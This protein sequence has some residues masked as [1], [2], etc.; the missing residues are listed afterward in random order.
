LARFGSLDTQYFDDAGN[1]LV[2]G[3]IY[4]YETGTTT[5]KNTYADPSYAIPNANPVILT[6]AGRQPNIF[7]PGAAKAILAKSDDTQILVRDPVGETESSFGDAWIASKDYNANAVVQGSDGQFYVSLINGNVN[8][9]PVTTSGSWTFLYSVEWNAG[10]TYKLGSVVTYQS[11]VYQSLQNANL[12]Q[13]PST[14]TAFWVPIQLVWSSTSTYALHA[15]VVGT[16]GVLYTSIQAANTGNVPA[17][18]PLWWAGTSA[19]AAASAAAASVSQSAALASQNAAAASQA[20]ATASQLAASNSAAA[21]AASAAA[22][23]AASNAA[24]WVSG[25]AYLAGDVVWSPISFLSYRA[26]VNTSGTT[27]PSLSANWELLNAGGITNVVTATTATTLTNTKTLLQITPASYGVVVTLPD[28][29]TMSEGGP[30]HCIDNRGNYHVRVWDNDGTLLGFVSPGASCPVY[31]VDNSTAAGVWGIVGRE[32]IGISATLATANFNGGLSLGTEGGAGAV[33]MGGGFEVLLG[34]RQ[35]DGYATAVVHK[36][37]T[38]EFGAVSVFRAANVGTANVAGARYT[39]TSLLVASYITTAVELVV[40]SFNTGTLA[41]TVNTPLAITLSASSIGVNQGSML[42]KNPDVADS[43]AFCVL[44]SGGSPQLYAVNVSGTTVTASAATT[45]VGTSYSMQY[46]VGSVLVMA[47]TTTTSLFV[48]PYT[49][50]GTTVTAGTGL[51]ISGGTMTMNRFF[52][53]GSRLCILY[54]DGGSTI[55]GSIVSL[56]G[57]TVTQS[58]ATLHS[59]GTLADAAIV[60]GKVLTLNNQSTDNHNLLTDSAGTASAGTP[61]S[62]YAAGL[63]VFSVFGSSALTYGTGPYFYKVDCSGASPTTTMVY[64]TGGMTTVNFP[65]GASNIGLVL[66]SKI[67]KAGSNALA[68]QDNFGV[69]LT[70][71]TSGEYLSIVTQVFGAVAYGSQL[72][73]GRNDAERWSIGSSTVQDY[74]FKTELAA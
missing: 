10:T 19:A 61:A 9:N 72:S 63:Y 6:A 73:R 25:Q 17:S 59:A 20:S 28:A 74:V 54:N 51:T 52:K 22:S 68:Y 69:P 2:S 56:S 4:F 35:S 58:S 36:R 67:F 23:E 33:D 39:A 16:D 31:L 14:I 65:D 40:L 50:T 12:N 7:F 32:Q 38:G 62:S 26:K 49:I 1:P 27:D 3:K 70:F 64:R 47:N 71:I 60:G 34:Y 37:A 44:V 48:E 29:T 53:L 15:N 21:A 66:S 43:F 57:T 5:P 13:N 55:K 24:G 8:N 45:A 11:I 46:F 41:I 18:S 42:L 30:V